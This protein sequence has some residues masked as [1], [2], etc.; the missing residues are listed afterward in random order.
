ME[1][2]DRLARRGDGT[3]AGPLESGSVADLERDAS[4]YRDRRVVLAETSEVREIRLVSGS[5]AIR[6]WR[7]AADRPWMARDEPGGEPIR[8]SATKI[9]DL[10]DRLRWLRIE[11]FES[12][13]GPIDRT[14]ILSGDR[15]E[16]GRIGW[17]PASGAPP[18][19][20]CGAT[21]SWRPG[22]A[23]VVDPDRL[24]SVPEKAADLADGGTP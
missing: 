15:G 1:G 9:D 21:S 17:S 5:H 7:E 16:L 10:L 18:A 11:G 24:G 23:F 4:E 2:G 6:A 12:P 14:L 20:R 3:L 8:A 13:L 22:V 19:R